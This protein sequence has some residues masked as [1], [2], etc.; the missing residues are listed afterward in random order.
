MG[1]FDKIKKI[2]QKEPDRESYRD[3]KKAKELNY[4]DIARF[5]KY[6]DQKIDLINEYDKQNISHDSPLYDSAYRE[7]KRWQYTL[8]EA[9]LKTDFIRENNDND[10]KYR[11]ENIPKFQRNIYFFV[12]DELK[13]ELRFHGTPIYFAKEIIKS[14]EI[15]SSADRFDGYVQSTD[16]KGEFSVSDINSLNRT[17]NWFLNVDAYNN[18]LPCGAIF[19]VS[20]EGQTEQQYKESV[21]NS[22]DFKSDPNKLFAV[23][24]TPEN[25]N[26]IQQWLNDAGLDMDKAYT[27]EEYLEEMTLLKHNFQKK[28]S[29]DQKINNFNIENDN[30]KNNIIKEEFC[31]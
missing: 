11:R 14:G 3:Y 25:K 8:Y 16:L 6:I 5:Q 2:I 18:C 20:S 13:D 9:K 22:L 10:I 23:I 26:D 19:V 28:E 21:M 7:L 24:S 12:P 4:S 15:S 29:L 27:F 1:F 17:I 31:L 30:E